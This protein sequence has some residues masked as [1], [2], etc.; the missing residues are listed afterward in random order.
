MNAKQKKRLIFLSAALAA[1]VLVFLILKNQNAA[2]TDEAGDTADTTAAAA[3]SVTELSYSN[4]SVTLRFSR[5][6]GGNWYWRED[7]GFPLDGVRVDAIAAAAADLTPVSSV[8][9]TEADA[10][11]AYGLQSPARYVSYTLSDGTAATLYLG[12]QSADGTYYALQKDGDG[13]VWLIDAAL[14]DQTASDINDLALLPTLPAI[15]DDAVRQVHITASGLDRTVTVTSSDGTAVWSCDGADV[16]DRQEVAGFR[17]AIAGLAVTAC[18]D[19][20]PSAEAYALCGLTDTAVK[21][22]VSYAGTPDGQLS[23]TV[24][25]ARDT[26]GGYFVLLGDSTIYLM[27]ASQASAL[28]A[29]AGSWES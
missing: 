21:I 2:S 20:R 13:S 26:G 1:A 3:A 23:V 6:S 10:L 19:Y 25:A 15:T 8:P 4:G 28:L 22:T 17:S 18:V 9:A 11:E 12:S 29:M 27:S 16:T 14:S 24:G 7:S 5:D